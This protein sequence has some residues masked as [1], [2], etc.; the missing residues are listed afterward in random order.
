MIK[1]PASFKVIG[2]A[3][4][5]WWDDLINL[6]LLNIVWLLC[7]LTIVFG[8]PATF[9]MYAI[10]HQLITGDSPN[11]KDLFTESR[12]Y[13]SSSW[14]WI[15]VNTLLLILI[16][17]NIQF[18]SKLEANWTLYAQGFFIAIISF[19]SMIQFYS[20][21]Y[22]IIQEQKS[23]RLAWKNGLLT[24]LAFPGYTLILW[25]F[26]LVV[27]SFSIIFILPILFSTWVFIIILGTRAVLERLETI[28][29]DC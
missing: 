10:S 29:I 27:I 3:F 17:I 6:I 7:W 18:Y 25:V 14:I 15:W 22:L 13:I 19:W 23:L 8:P 5:L 9:G 2:Q 28:D 26:T 11:P 24:T 4:T 20:I 12:R 21:P 16:W 1:I